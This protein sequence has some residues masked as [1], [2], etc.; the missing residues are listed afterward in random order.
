MK[1][2][3]R[4]RTDSPPPPRSDPAAPSAAPPAAPP[5]APSAA[6][7]LAPPVSP[8]AALLA[9]SSPSPE[10]ELSFQEAFAQHAQ[11]MEDRRRSGE[12]LLLLIDD[13]PG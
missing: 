6:P 10:P 11:E 3:W 5:A 9:Y 13:W 7:P 12:S 1:A 8:L 2:T 4:T